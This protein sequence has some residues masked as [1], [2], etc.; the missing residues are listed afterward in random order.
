MTYVWEAED[1]VV[2]KLLSK[3]KGLHYKIAVT[4]KHVYRYQC[5]VLIYAHNVIVTKPMSNKTMC[6]Y[7]SD[8][9]FRY[10]P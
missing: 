4:E 5:Y 8:N 7:L 3:G 1:I 9:G 2:G 10:L 6:S